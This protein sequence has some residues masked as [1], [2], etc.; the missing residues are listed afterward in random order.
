VG[1]GAGARA[2][3]NFAGSTALLVATVRGK[4]PLALFLLDRGADPNVIEAGFTPLHW[5]A[6][7]W[8]NGLA[9]P[10]YGFVDPIGGI[11]DP[12]NSSIVVST[13]PIISFA[14][15]SRLRTASGFAA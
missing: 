5:A 3:T 12:R 14:L 9:N 2:G 4:V 1:G 7:T 10:V 6:G 13:L 11:P 15:V 8:E